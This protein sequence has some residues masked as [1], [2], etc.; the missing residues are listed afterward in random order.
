MDTELL[1]ESHI[2]DGQRLVEQLV[3]DDFEISVAF[4]VKT[5]EEGLWHLYIASPS[6]DEDKLGEAYRKL[7]ASLA[8]ISDSTVSPSD[9]KLINDANAISRDVLAIR[10]RYP[11]KIPTRFRG[12]RIG[13]VSIV[14]A[15]IYPTPM[16]PRV[17]TP[18][19]YGARVYL[20]DDGV[21]LV[22]Q[23]VKR[24]VKQGERYVLDGQRQQH[25]DPGDDAA[26]GAAVRAALGG[27]L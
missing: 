9:I 23:T 26:L 2:D 27:R 10:D 18:T 6:V 14:E 22:M 20:L 13:N 25:V 8:K 16:R 5:S 11:A 17:Q 3:R 7:Y 12:K 19:K 15:Y 24:K 1:V 4:W 21:A